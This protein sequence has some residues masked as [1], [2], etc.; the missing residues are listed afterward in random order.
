MCL[1]LGGVL[2]AGCASMPD[3][4]SVDR[5]NSSHRAEANSQVRVYSVSPQKGEKPQQIVRGFLEA[6]TSDEADFPTAR[7]Y[8]TSRMAGRWNPKAGTTVLSDGPSTDRAPRSRTSK[9]GYAV[10]VSGTR[11]A[12]VDAK[13][14]Y[15]P[16][17]GEYSRLFHLTKVAGEWRIDRMPDGLVLGESDFQRIYRPVNTY[18]YARLG[19][20]A[21]SITDGHNVL[22]ADPVYLRRRINPV[23]ETVAALLQGPSA[24]LDPVVD[25]AFPRD[26]RLAPKG[27]HLSL[28][29]SGDLRVKLS[30]KGAGVGGRQCVRMAA[31]V[32]HS[33]Q[34]Q[35]SAKVNKV[36]LQDA[37]GRALCA[38]TREEAAN[39]FMPGRLNGSAKRAYFI[40]EKH[41]VAAFGHKGDTPQPVGGPLGAGTVEMGAVAVNRLESEGAA[42]SRGRRALYVAPLESST[43]TSPGAPV[44]TSSAKH[45]DDRLSA[46]SWD[47]L[48]D[49]WIADRNPQHPR[50]I[51]L[52]AGKED[53]EEIPVPDLT[54]GRRIES[55]HI[56][57]D[58]VRIALRVKEPD[59]HTS[60][61]LGRVVRAGTHDEPETRVAQLR[62][63]APQ[64][65]D[66]S[67]V[68]WA[69]VSRLVVV[70]RETGGVQQL[71]YVETDASVSDQPTL[72]GINDVMGV[73]ASE[74]ESRA[75][76]ASS[77]DGIVRLPPDA[78]W[79]TLTES[80][81]APAYPG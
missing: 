7:E 21:D 43:S 63:V 26:T 5:V 50:L 51:R 23:T 2:L 75:L 38:Q 11:M 4:G 16:S 29:D 56:S 62:S 72:P 45:E 22:V 40:D 79:K 33:V 19:Q 27:R 73:A 32:L 36:E 71:Q 13:H 65:E 35:A 55:L 17:K 18:Y 15:A 3:S 34:D 31:Q 28:D 58:G 70:G 74:D 78:N 52:R 44:L 81:S 42:V 67:A 77:E 12:E 1:A 64:L 48:G 25:S 10:E 24:W 30:G 59:G 80:G 53:P 46:P 57:S 68:S 66:V 9:D 41:R 6:T 37:K 47:G 20:D 49:L 8:L 69:G 76:L 39:T 61:Q 14:T 60:L 54:K